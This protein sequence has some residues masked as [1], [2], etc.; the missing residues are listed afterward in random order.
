M[1]GVAQ[2][3][4]DFTNGVLLLGVDADGNQ[5]GVLLDDAGNLNCI[6]KGQGATGLQTIA[7]DENGRIEVFILDA[8]SQWG[9]VL[10]TGNAELAA[11]LGSPKSWDWRGDVYYLTD[12]SKGTGNL[13]KYPAGTGSEIVIDPLYWVNGGYS[14]KIVGGSDDTE[15][16]YID[17]WVDHS[18]SD[19]MGLEV[20]I[21]GDLD[22]EYFYIRIRQ[23][24]GG[25][26]L[27]AGLKITG[28]PDPRVYY[29]NSSG[30]WAGGYTIDFGVNIE[31]FNHLKVVA[32]FANKK[33]VRGLWS[34]H[35]QDLSTFD[36]YQSG[37]G[38]LNQTV[39]TVYLKARS[40]NNDVRYL[41]YV[42][43]TVNEPD[44]I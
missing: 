41:D 42:L 22:F 17:V 35:E 37:T 9:D 30:N 44:N 3:F 34:D 25:K 5:V 43:A 13:L 40:G 1:V 16:A 32:D 39:L 33:Y 27:D 23:Y 38:Y 12:F 8:Q 7:V 21:S 10:R 14:L 20:H 4:P 2:D 29:L 31:M 15:D 28:S 18:P 19:T 11:R 6:L 26:V 36:L 24:I